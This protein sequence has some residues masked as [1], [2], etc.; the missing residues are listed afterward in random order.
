MK[1]GDSSRCC[2]SAGKP[3]KFLASIATVLINRMGRPLKTGR[4]R[5]PAVQLLIDAS[6]KSSD[7]HYLLISFPVAIFHSGAGNAYEIAMYEI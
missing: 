1:S 4:V 5:R 2:N 3:V 7:E 6:G